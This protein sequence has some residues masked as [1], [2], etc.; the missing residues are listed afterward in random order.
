[1]ARTVDVRP[2][3]EFPDDEQVEI[4]GSKVAF[5]ALLGPADAGKPK[6]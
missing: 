2:V 5:D 1:M 6:K 4:T 3:S